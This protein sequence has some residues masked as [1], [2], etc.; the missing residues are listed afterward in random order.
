MIR[1]FHSSLGMIIG[2]VINENLDGDYEIKNPVVIS[3]SQ[4]GVHF[5]PLLPCVKE[6]S[7][8]MKD[9]DIIGKPMTP[10]DQI[11]SEYV[12]MF[13]KIELPPTPNLTLVK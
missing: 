10:L 6:D 3:P 8:E 2:E 12:K 4:Q 1:V 11:E 5:I 9:K 7:I 13:S